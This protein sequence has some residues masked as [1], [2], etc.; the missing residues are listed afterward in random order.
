MAELTTLG[1]V[2]GALAT[3]NGA[4]S[5]D[6][7]NVSDGVLDGV[8]AR[9]TD[10]GAA[11]DTL[12]NVTAATGR[13]ALSVY[14]QAQVD[15]SLAAK[16]PI[17]S[18]TFTGTPTAPTLNID[19]DGVPTNEGGL[20]RFEPYEDTT[21]YL[22]LPATGVRVYAKDQTGADRLIEAWATNYDH[23]ATSLGFP[24]NDKPSG[25][26]GYR[27]WYTNR[28]VITST[29]N[30]RAGRAAWTPTIV[31][32]VITA[33]TISGGVTTGYASGEVVE[34]YADGAGTGF[35]ATATANGSG[36]IS[37]ATITNGGTG[38]VDGET[39]VGSEP[40]ATSQVLDTSTLELIRD[41]DADAGSHLWTIHVG[42]RR[43]DDTLGY[44]GSWGVDSVDPVDGVGRHVFS[45]GGP[46]SVNAGVNPKWYIG[47]G[48]YPVGLTDLG[49]GTISALDTLL[50]QS[51]DAGAAVGPIFEVYRNS[52]SAA[53]GDALGLIRFVGRD[54]GG[55]VA[56][57][58]AIRG[59][60]VFAN[61]GNHYGAVTVQTTNAGT[62][63]DR[64]RFTTTFTAAGL[65]DSGAAGSANLTSLYINNTQVLTGQLTSIADATSEADVVTKFNS[66]LADLKAKKLMA[67]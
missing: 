52:A 26:D 47:E 4:A 38:Y 20:F 9:A 64:F 29:Q 55:D 53:N 37:T 35:A 41:V 42:G 19:L 8:A 44:Y 59:D 49:D 2:I 61:A 22:D 39:V 16:A 56:Y 32:G 50:L 21:P 12:S 6:L 45:I 34:L 14:S 65:T 28:F 66:L 27:Y 24:N 17:A 58:G 23:T 67:P 10:Q 13:A 1:D 57:Y 15:A 5:D 63:A 7:S 33:V 62:V 48:I 60:I 36:V 18:P 3:A 31:G 54:A 40:P 51:N 11:T 30:L 46:Y 43:S 25:D